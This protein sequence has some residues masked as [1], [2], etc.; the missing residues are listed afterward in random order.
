MRELRLRRARRVAAEL[1]D[2]YSI[3]HPDQLEDVAWLLRAQVIEGGLRG[4]LARVARF[5]RTAR[6]RLSHNHVEPGQRRFSIAHELGHLLL[7]HRGVAGCSRASDVSASYKGDGKL[8]EEEAN[9]F[10]GDFLLPTRLVKP[11]CEVSP[12]D[13]GVIQ[14]IADDFGTSLVATAIRFAELT[15]ERC[16]VVLSQQNKVRW[17][18]SSRTFWPEIRRGQ[19]VLPWSV[20]APYFRGKPLSAEL[21]EVDAT[22][23]I[24]GDHMRGPT[25]IYEHARE[26][27][28]IKGVLS[29]VWIPESCSELTWR[30]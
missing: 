27:P 20:A 1:V 24:D 5:D 14:K 30:Q 12:V 16:A 22:A 26:I 29:L 28:S 25:E 3:D 15:S 10:A 2:S 4:S 18:V 19:P 6:I 21:E 23:W 7:G 9:V 17:V 11:R 8:R 13:F